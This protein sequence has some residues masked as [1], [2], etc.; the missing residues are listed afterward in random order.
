VKRYHFHINKFER[1]G[2]TNTF[3]VLTFTAEAE[4]LDQAYEQV[5]DQIPEE[6]RV[7]AW[8]TEETIP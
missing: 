8:W 2:E 5:K 7:W 6:H 1:V 3:K 4:T